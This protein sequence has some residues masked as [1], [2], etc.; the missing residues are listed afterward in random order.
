MKILKKKYDLSIVIPTINDP[1][2]LLSLIRSID[3]Q[4]SLIRKKIELIIVVQ[5]RSVSYNFFNNYK[6]I[7]KIIIVNQSKKSLSIAKNTGIKRS[8]GEL[9]C[10]LDDDISLDKSFI[11]NLLNFFKKNHK[12]DLLFGSIK[13][14]N[15][16]QY[17]SRY[18]S[19]LPTK[20]NFF[21]M[22]KCLASAMILKAR[23]NKNLFDINFGLGAKFP[24]SEETDFLIS[25]II[26]YKRNIF[27]DPKIIVY[28]KN[29]EFLGKDLNRIK[30][31]FYS[32]GLGSGAMHA[33]YIKKN[34]IFKLLMIFELIKSFT[35]I[36]IGIL[37]FNRHYIFKHF[38]LLNGKTKGFFKYFSSKS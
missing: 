5:K 7:H 38:F 31:K 4:N 34:F 21:N 13:I 2:K 24:S 18:M 17:Y 23:T 3:Y 25:S 30:K 37:I 14:T 36:V 32:Y 16:N 10:F 1:I 27:Y 19:N 26:N 9:I 8:S 20:I 22:K 11:F 28:H 29:D 6:N 35:G 33:K 12:I 15:R